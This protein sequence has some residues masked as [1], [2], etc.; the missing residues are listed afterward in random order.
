M[1]RAARVARPIT[2]VFAIAIA[3]TIHPRVHAQPAIP[4]AGAIASPAVVIDLPSASAS[5][6]QRVQAGSQEAIARLT[7]WLGPAPFTSLR[8]VNKP[9]RGAIS[10]AASDVMLDVPWRSLPETMDLESQAAFGVAHLWWPRLL[11][12][13]DTAPLANGLAWYLQSR[14]VDR[15]FDL[16]FLVPAHSAT[17]VRQFGDAWPK[18]F[19]ILPLG[20]SVGGLGRD[21]YLRSR[22][23]RA[24]WPAPAR[25]LP[26]GLTPSA[27]RNALAFGTLEQLVGWPTLQGALRVM[28][29]AASRRSMTRQEVEQSIAAA[30]GRDLAWFFSLAFDQ[31]TSV[32]Y[33]VRDLTTGEVAPCGHGPCFKTRVTVEREGAGEF[34]G[35]SSASTAFESGDAMELRVVFADGQHTSTRW[36][37]RAQSRTFE[38]D[39]A[40]EAVSATVDPD[41]MLLLDENTLNN[42]IHRDTNSRVVLS[43]WVTYWMVWLEGAVLDFGMFF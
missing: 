35:S 12:S 13:S 37:G 36:D 5:D 15:L 19:S 33:A 31:A 11:Q 40:S 21:E 24:S 1:F 41:R 18:A 7:D 8:V 32:D 28:T 34:T 39:S 9:W 26:P 6:R 42:A 17:G 43:K 30:T 4:P 14:I 3:A 38:F 16:N 10:A 29:E 2:G 20:R 27:L 22:S 25:R 23:T